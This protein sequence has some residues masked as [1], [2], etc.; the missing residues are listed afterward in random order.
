MIKQS[1]SGFYATFM[2]EKNFYM[3]EEVICWT[4]LSGRERLRKFNNKLG[5]RCAKL[6]L[7]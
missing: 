3:Q 6:I 2:L 5:L 4:T 1:N 7:S